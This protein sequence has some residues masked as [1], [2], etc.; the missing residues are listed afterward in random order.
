VG[1]GAPQL[2]LQLSSCLPTLQEVLLLDRSHEDVYKPLH[3]PT[4]GVHVL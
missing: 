2:L 4:A 3:T 1:V